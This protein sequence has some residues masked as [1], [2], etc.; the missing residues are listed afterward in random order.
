MTT[1]TIKHLREDQDRMHFELMMQDFIKRWS[2]KNPD[3]AAQFQSQLF[4]IARTLFIDV[5]KPVQDTVAAIMSTQSNPRWG[6]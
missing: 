4:G 2:P 1:P 6:D 3:E 5:Q